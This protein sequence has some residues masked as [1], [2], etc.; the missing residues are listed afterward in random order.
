MYLF[1][2]AAKS[3][4]VSMP[5][6]ITGLRLTPAVK[7]VRYSSF[8]FYTLFAYS[9]IH[10]IFR[11]NLIEAL[12]DIPG[13]DSGLKKENMPGHILEIFFL[14]I[15]ISGDS[16]HEI[17]AIGAAEFVE[18]APQII[19]MPKTHDL[20]QRRATIGVAEYKIGNKNRIFEIHNFGFALEIPVGLSL[21]KAR[22]KSLFQKRIVHSLIFVVR[23]QIVVVVQNKIAFA[24]IFQL[25]RGFHFPART[26]EQRRQ[27][28]SHLNPVFLREAKQAYGTVEDDFVSRISVAADIVY[29]TIKF[30]KL[31]KL[32]VAHGQVAMHRKAHARTAIEHRLRECDIVAVEQPRGIGRVKAIEIV[33]DGKVCVEAMRDIFRRSLIFERDLIENVFA[34]DGI[35]QD[36]VLGQRGDSPG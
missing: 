27:K 7:R 13:L 28:N 33:I 12:D 22:G 8:T 14:H 5:V 17:F 34:C 21:F 31:E 36:R 26:Q 30:D 4:K 20:E 19:G 23:N 25:D 1:F 15:E 24:P 6:K 11:T 35:E 32:F 2:D 3:I 9:I 10:T 16:Y 29:Q 18:F